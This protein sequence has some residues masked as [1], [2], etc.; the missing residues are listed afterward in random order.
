M[1]RQGSLMGVMAAVAMLGAWG[2]PGV[3]H[4]PSSVVTI[5][6]TAGTGAGSALSS[7]FAGMSRRSMRFIGGGS[8]GY[9]FERSTYRKYPHGSVA[10]DKRD[11]TK[12]R[13]QLRN[14]R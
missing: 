9:G 14:K 1:R 10:R 8:A 3:G 6:N 7:A 13:N 4:I 11:A 2:A 5:S 12:R